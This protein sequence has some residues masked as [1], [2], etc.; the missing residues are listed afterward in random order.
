MVKQL[1][2]L[3]WHHRHILL[4]NN[5]TQIEDMVLEIRVWEKRSNRLANERNDKS[6]SH[7][8]ILVSSIMRWRLKQKISFAFEWGGRGMAGIWWWELL[9]RSW[10][11]IMAPAGD[12]SKQFRDLVF[13]GLWDRFT[14]IATS[15][16]CICLQKVFIIW[17]FFLPSP[18]TATT[19]CSYTKLHGGKRRSLSQV[20][21]LNFFTLGIKK[22]WFNYPKLIIVLVV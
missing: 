10:V 1:S 3:N 12:L 22:L 2:H 4:Y 14:S 11:R 13:I 20:C 9:L 16:I 5:N 7:H 18:S 21:L 6:P 8:Q 15:N 17:C 19:F